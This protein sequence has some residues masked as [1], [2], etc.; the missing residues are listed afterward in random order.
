MV[1][2]L[3]H[4]VF[5]KCLLHVIMITH[6][7]NYMTAVVINMVKMLQSC[8]AIDPAHNMSALRLLKSLSEQ[9]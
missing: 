7:S 3:M 6:S 4:S 2:Y 9:P 5:V 8:Y 1:F